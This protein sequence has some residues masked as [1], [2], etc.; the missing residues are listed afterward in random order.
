MTIHQLPAP[1]GEDE[2]DWLATEITAELSTTPE[3]GPRI[4]G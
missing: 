2:A 3:I 1:T 4:D